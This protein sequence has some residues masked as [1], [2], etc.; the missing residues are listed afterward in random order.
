MS[1]IK[2]RNWNE[3]F[4]RLK[5]YKEVNG[6]CLVPRAYKQDPQLGKWLSRQRHQFNKGKLRKDRQTRLESIALEWSP[7]VARSHWEDKFNEL[8]EFK[9]KN[10]HSRVPTDHPLYNWTTVQRERRF[11]PNYRRR[12]I[13]QQEINRLDEIG[14][15]WT[16]RDLDKLWNEM[17]RRL[18]RY[19]LSHGNCLVPKRYEEDPKLGRW[20]AYQR[21]M[22]KKGRLNSERQTLLEQN[23]FVWSLRESR[24]QPQFDLRLNK[25]WE[26]NYEKLCLFRE[27]NG[28]CLV[29]RS[30]KPLGDWILT[31]RKHNRLSQ[32][33]ADRKKKLDEIDFV[34]KV[35]NYDS[36]TSRNQRD[37]NV[38]LGKL[39]A[40]KEEHGHYRVPCSYHKDQRLGMWVADQRWLCSIV[41]L[42]PSR[43]NQLDAVGFLWKV[44]V[45]DQRDLS[46]KRKGVP[47]QEVASVSSNSSS[48]SIPRAKKQ[49]TPKS[50]DGS[51]PAVGQR[52]AV[53]WQN[54]DVYYPG[55][56]SQIKTNG[57]VRVHYDD[58]DKEWVKWDTR[59]CLL[60]SGSAEDQRPD[61][62][63]VA[64]LRVGS[65]LS[66]WWNGE[67]AFFLGRLSKIKASRPKP[68]YIEYEDGDTEWTDLAY[69][70]FKLDG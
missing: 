34:W 41:R 50:R 40:F 18:K 20:V 13:D 45:K 11:N 65:R 2:E 24:H 64:D 8:A 37:W 21:N 57:K 9:N 42:H 69:R 6:N 47:T 44:S 67:R 17:L 66:V 32:M 49:N 53:H 30:D 26:E 33:R 3:L 15:E 46:L 25:K 29:P 59:K 61:N 16:P 62:P 27:E 14:F 12:S 70:R 35:D 38:M 23:G 22:H 36:A 56:V 60:L 68:H 63:K 48:G 1:T 7:E 39:I 51:I 28:H 10:G 4:E 58:G 5:R 54:V 55:V 52:V 31:Q 19:K 43:K